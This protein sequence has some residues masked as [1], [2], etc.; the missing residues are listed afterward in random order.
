MRKLFLKM[1]SMEKL[2]V[3]A[4]KSKM[5]QGTSSPEQLLTHFKDSCLNL[6]MIYLMLAQHES[7]GKV[8]NYSK[9]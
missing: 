1:L 7:G 3:Q 5:S 6:N 9:V 4:E 8:E 2:R